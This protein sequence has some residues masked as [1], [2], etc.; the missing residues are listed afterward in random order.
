MSDHYA[1]TPKR[2]LLFKDPQ[3]TNLCNSVYVLPS[4]RTFT[5]FDN[6]R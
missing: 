5:A 3:P 6:K 2:A 1:T 4:K